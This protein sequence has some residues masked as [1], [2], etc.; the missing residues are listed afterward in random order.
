MWTRL[1]AKNF[2]VEAKVN[3]KIT[4]LSYVVH[5]VCFYVYLPVMLSVLNITLLCICTFLQAHFVSRLYP[6][7]IHSTILH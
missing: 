3:D 6:R 4:S 1:K 5:C 2:S 7:H